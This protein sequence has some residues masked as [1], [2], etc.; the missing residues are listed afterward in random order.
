MPFISGLSPTRRRFR[1]LRRHLY[2]RRRWLAAVLVA[3]AVFA[4]LRALAP[5]HPATVDV[6][7]AARP[8]PAG[9]VLAAD[10]LT[11][12]AFPPDLA[13]DGLGDD[14]VGR[15]L[16]SAVNA[17]E[18]VTDVRLVGPALSR[19]RPG[20]Q[21]VPV[22]LPDAGMAALLRPGDTV[23]LLSTDPASGESRVVATDVTVLALPT[24][25]APDGGSNGA[26]GALVV[27]SLGA[28]SVRTVTGA[29]LAEFLTVTY[30]R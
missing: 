20:E 29:S 12:V 6:A 19:A 13:P 17:G 5:P 28:E 2:L 10:D 14:L 4:A 15:A 11:T 8:L 23:D 21:A 3:T 30:S 26:S 1:T 16:A 24:E 27:V 9:T 18:P 7:V 25:T 22:R